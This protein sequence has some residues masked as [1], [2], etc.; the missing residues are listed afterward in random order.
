MR[1]PV[2]LLYDKTIIMYIQ[3]LFVMIIFDM[4]S[5]LSNKIYRFYIY[6]YKIGTKNVKKK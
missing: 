2:D 6:N 3:L 4:S 1:I 5:K